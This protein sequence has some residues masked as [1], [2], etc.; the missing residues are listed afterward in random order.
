MQDPKLAAGSTVDELGIK[1]ADLT[2]A[3]I[4]RF[5]YEGFKG[6][7]VKEVEP[8]GLAAQAGIRG[9][10]LIMQVEKKAV[11]SAAEFKQAMKDQSLSKGVMLLFARRKAAIGWCR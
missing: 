2:K 6:A 3:D 4:E 5:G 10:M 7:L 9:G 8:D 1:V 11:R